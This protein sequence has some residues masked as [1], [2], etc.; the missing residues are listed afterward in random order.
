MNFSKEVKKNRM[1]IIETHCHLDYLK[2]AP[3]EEI[4]QRCTD[5]NIEKIITIGVDPENLDKVFELSNIHKMIYFSQGIHPHDAKDA[6]DDDMKKIIARCKEPKMLAVGEIGLDYH[7]NNSPRD[8]QISRFEEQLQI[9]VDNNKPVIIHS[10]DADDDMMAIIKN[11]GHKLSCNGV[12]HSFTSTKKLAEV[13]LDQGFYLGF[14]G[15]IT[16]EKMAELKEVDI[17][18]ASEVFYDNSLKLFKF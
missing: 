14:N 6:R 11:F 1:K 12:I 8:I 17:E 16:L 4:L 3:L 10:R 7:Y 5:A 9:A 18:K 2:Q 15:I 13:A